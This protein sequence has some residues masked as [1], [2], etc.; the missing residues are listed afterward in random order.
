MTSF[1]K[2]IQRTVSLYYKDIHKCL[3]NQFNICIQKIKEEFPVQETL[4]LKKQL[5]DTIL[6]KSFS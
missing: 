5:P 3:N 2:K 1:F 6:S 4:L